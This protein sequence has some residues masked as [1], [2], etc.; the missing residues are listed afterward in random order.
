MAFFT[1]KLG[2][3][4]GTANTLVF[5]PK[6]GVVLNEPSVVALSVLNNMVLA[7]GD[8]AK[9]M[10]GRTPE[11]IA[12][13]RPL[14]DGVIADYRVTEAMLRYFIH[15]A[16]PGP[17]IFKP[18]VMVSVPAGVTS[19]ERRA[20][21][22]AALKAGARAAYV[23]KEP[24]LAAIGAGIPISEA[25]GHM[26]VDIGG[27]TT[28]AAVISLGGIVASTSAKVAGNKIDQAVADYI[29]EK[30]SPDGNIDAEKFHSLIA[31]I[32][33]EIQRLNKLVEEFLDYGKPL[34]LNLLRTGIGK[35]LEEITELIGAKAEAEKIKI[36]KDC[37][38]LPSLNMDT[39]LIKTCVFNVVLNAFQAMP[40]GGT[41]T[42]KTEPAE[43]MLSI[44]ISDTGKGIPED[45]LPKVFEPFYT[46][47]RNG[48]GLG[49][50]MTKRV[51]EEHQGTVS[52]QSI[53]G[54]GSTVVINLPVQQ[55]ISNASHII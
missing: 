6:K 3:D 54:K 14:K 32:K 33:Q 10:I 38:F 19:T 18:E 46:T 43:G 39:D 5:V 47:K 20:V 42:I 51:V 55:N 36:I 21:V 9:E 27:G 7:V 45:E 48:L 37:N 24:I 15:K 49:L 17:R 44:I 34:R 23:V 26:V 53:E 22:E 2:I 41:L 28:D 29:K 1:P 52:I 16:L 31:N 8:E 11:S 40:D 13:Y 25:R 12:A 30:F 50:A 35:L 4:L